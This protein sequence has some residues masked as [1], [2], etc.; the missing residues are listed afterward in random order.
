LKA[1]DKT[2]ARNRVEARTQWG[3]SAGVTWR[4]KTDTNRTVFVWEPNSTIPLRLAYFCH[5]WALGT[6]QLFGYTVLSGE[7]LRIVLESEWD[8]IT[9]GQPAKGD[10]CVWY[11]GSDFT[12]PLH[13]AKVE[14]PGGLIEKRQVSS[15]DGGT[16][17]RQCTFF[18]VNQEYR[19]APHNCTEHHYYRRRTPL[20]TVLPMLLE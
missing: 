11:V 18:E 1:I 13:S 7:D 19:K 6:W 3:Q 10:I 5:G 8:R 16:K 14:V 15:K 4:A 2:N 9:E 12:M 17:L 20:V